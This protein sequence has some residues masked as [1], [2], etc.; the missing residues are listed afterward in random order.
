L[1]I[2]KGQYKGLKGKLVKYDYIPTYGEQWEVLVDDK[3]FV[4][5][6]DEEYLEF[7]NDKYK[8]IS[9]NAYMDEEDE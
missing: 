9:I 6:I 3:Y 7:E 2:V 4:R 1:T 5:F 8:D